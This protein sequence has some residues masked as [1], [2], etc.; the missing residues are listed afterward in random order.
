MNVGDYLLVDARLHGLDESKNWSQISEEEQQIV[1]RGYSH[2][3]NNHFAFGPVEMATSSRADSMTF[4]YDV[5]NRI[6]VVSGGINVVTYCTGLETLMRTTGEPIRK[7]RL[8]LAATTLY[9]YD[10]LR[11]WL[12]TR[13]FHE[14]WSYK[15]NKEALFLL[16]KID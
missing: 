15:S 13:G 8:D 1:T 4:G 12:M 16:R 3:E 5:N 7:K 2:N 10:S 6:T 14:V 11:N 9:S